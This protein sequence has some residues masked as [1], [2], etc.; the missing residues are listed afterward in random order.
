MLKLD[1]GDNVTN[2]LLDYKDHYVHT[3]CFACPLDAA[4]V[5]NTDAVVA[6]AAAGAVASSIVEGEETFSALLLASRAEQEELQKHVV[7]GNWDEKG[8]GGGAN[9]RLGLSVVALMVCALAITAIALVMFALR[10]RVVRRRQAVLWDAAEDSLAASRWVLPGL[11]RIDAGTGAEG[12]VLSSAPAANSVTAPFST[13]PGA[14]TSL[15]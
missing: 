15:V 9:E 7:P 5:T 6:E 10:S 4:C 3:F 8:L 14:A 12:A 13:G 11:G 1:H 2:I